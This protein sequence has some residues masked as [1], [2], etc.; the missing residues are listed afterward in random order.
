MKIQ[1]FQLNSYI[2]V[3]TFK[4]KYNIE[5]NTNLTN[6]F[7]EFQIFFS[8]KNETNESPRMR[9]FRKKLRE[10]TPIG[11]LFLFKNLRKFMKIVFLFKK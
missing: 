10:R 11:I 7:L 2:H 3:S 1:K 8:K 6:W 9:E 5:F 4:I